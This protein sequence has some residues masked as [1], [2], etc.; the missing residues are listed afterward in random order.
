MGKLTRDDIDV[1]FDDVWPHVEASGDFSELDE[2]YDE[3]LT[4]YRAAVELNASEGSDKYLDDVETAEQWLTE[5]LKIFI[6][7]KRNPDQLN[8]E[9]G[10]I[11]RLIEVVYYLDKAKFD[12]EIELAIDE[13]LRNQ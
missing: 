2:A 4:A 8:R 1:T 11:K 12:N 5:A 10:Y 13:A 3:A 6:D 7:A 9:S